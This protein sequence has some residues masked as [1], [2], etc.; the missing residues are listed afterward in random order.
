MHRIESSRQKLYVVQSG[1]ATH[2]SG[3]IRRICVLRK[4]LA[5]ESKRESHLPIRHR[6][7]R[8]ITTEHHMNDDL[9][10]RFQELSMI[11][12]RS[13]GTSRMRVGGYRH[14][15]EMRR[16]LAE[17]C[18]APKPKAEAIAYVETM[19]IWFQRMQRNRGVGMFL[20]PEV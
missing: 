3:N 18:V 19:P 15:R 11:L 5:Y 14:M 6:E 2:E 17:T 13:A 8:V 1:G 7:P 4:Y 16:L 20:H 12:V 10:S 9:Y